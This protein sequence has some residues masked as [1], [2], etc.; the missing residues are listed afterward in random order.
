MKYPSSFNNTIKIR[1][2]LEDDYG[3][4]LSKLSKFNL[5]KMETGQAVFKNSILITLALAHPYALL[6]CS[7]TRNALDAFNLE[8]DRSAMNHLKLA[9]DIKE[10]IEGPLLQMSQSHAQQRKKAS[11]VVQ[12][13]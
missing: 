4:K 2:Q 8:L 5:A 1:I 3:K 9:K 10:Q 13:S 12:A 11:T 7:T 6:F